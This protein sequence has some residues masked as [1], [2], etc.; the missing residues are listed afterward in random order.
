LQTPPLKE[1]Y[2]DY[3]IEI[4]TTIGLRTVVAMVLDESYDMGLYAPGVPFVELTVNEPQAEVYVTNGN[5]GTHNP[6][7]ITAIIE[8]ENQWLHDLLELTH[9]DLPYI[10]EAGENFMIT[11]APR[12]NFG[13]KQDQIHTS[14][15]VESD[16]NNVVF[17]IVIDE[18]L[19]SVNELTAE[20]KLYPNPT[21]GQFTVEGANV[22]KV[23]VYN[24]VGQKV[25]EQ[26]GSKV[27]N[28]DTTEW[29]KGIYLVNIIE[30]NGATLTKKLVVK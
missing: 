19:V 30:E 1:E 29:N 4:N 13:S 27:V 8:A 6:I 10:L 26:Q 16:D 11:I 5:Y 15:L 25:C 28:I 3:N 9:H 20:T 12:T 21:T 17:D 7:K 14:V 24:L 23:E 18:E 22:D 2:I